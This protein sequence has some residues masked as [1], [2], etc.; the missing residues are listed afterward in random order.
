MITQH[1]HD[2]TTR[3]RTHFL[4]HFNPPLSNSPTFPG[5]LSY[6]HGSLTLPIQVTW[7]VITEVRS[8]SFTLIT[9]RH[10][11]KGRHMM[12]RIFIVKCGIAR[13]LSTMRVF[14]VQASSSSPRLPLCQIC[15]FRSLHCQARPRREILYPI[16]HSTSL[17]DA[18]ACAL[19]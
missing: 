6:A 8:K 17:F 3:A 5:S 12:Q 14:K 16:T 2:N 4:S 19:E 13:F 1:K 15:F 18:P 11:W 10:R 7:L 9:E